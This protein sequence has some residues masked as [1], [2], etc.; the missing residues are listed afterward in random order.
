MPRFSITLSA[1]AVQRLQAI[2]DRY[3]ANTGQALTVSQWIHLHLL[4]LCVQDELAAALQQIE[5]RKRQ[6]VADEYRLERDRLI[7]GL[8]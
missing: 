3:N 2:V 8:Q 5:Q 1:A 7:Q 6:E 4:E